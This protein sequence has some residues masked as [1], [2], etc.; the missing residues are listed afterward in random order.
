MTISSISMARFTV[1]G[2]AIVETARDMV[3]SGEWA[4]AWAYFNDYFEDFPMELS[5][6]ILRGDKTLTGANDDIQVVEDNDS[7]DYKQ[8]VRE[9]YAEDCFYSNGEF[10]Q[11]SHMIEPKD[12]ERM[13]E[14]Y[15]LQHGSHF[16]HDKMFDAAVKYMSNK[17]TERLFRFGSTWFMVAEKKDPNTSPMWLKKSDFARSAMECYNIMNGIEVKKE[18]PK[19]EPQPDPV[20]EEQKRERSN[21]YFKNARMAYLEG[22]AQQYS[23][24][25]VDIMADTMRGKVLAAC[26]ERNVSWKEVQFKHNGEE[27]TQKVPVELVMA[28][29]TRDSS[30]W[31]PVCESGLKMEGDSSFHS[32][33]WLAMGNG[34]NGE[35]YNYD[36]PET[37]R[38]YDMIDS[39]RFFYQDAGDFSVLNDAKMVKFSGRV[40]FENSENITD[41]DILVLPNANLKYEAL[42]KK[43]GV[44]I[45]ERGGPVSHLV[46]VG[47]EDMFPVLIMKDAIQKLR[48]YENAEIDFETKTIKGN[49]GHKRFN[50][51]E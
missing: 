39:M 10:F 49:Y 12:F 1:H 8:T 31:K 50:R 22:M 34:L 9:V 37:S 21:A 43:A 44:V 45:T 18:A 19:P 16:D 24:P 2:S 29:I 4:K 30:I 11:Y 17:N 36:N 33:L 5:M 42:A 47:R 32:D 48:D 20:K 40:V 15:G 41:K 7:E 35:E 14:N 51:A 46:I 23:Y 28:Y 26:A 6:A 25:S 27:I 3:L 38:F 13:M